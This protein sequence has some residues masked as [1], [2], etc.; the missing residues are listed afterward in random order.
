MKICE[1]YT[2]IQG[3]S[4]YAG[5]PCTFIRLTG[6]NLRCTYCDTRYA[7]DEGNEL[8][9]DAI[10]KQVKDAG[11]QLVEITGGEPLLQQGVYHLITR[12]LEDGYLVMIETNGSQDIKDIH[13]KAIVILDI[14]TPGSGAHREMNFA[15]MDVLKPNDEV[16]FV[17]T[18]QE[19]YMWAKGIIGQY[20]LHEKC[21]ILLSPAYGMLEPGHLV[22]WILADRLP[23]RLNLQIHRY[24]FP[25]KTRGV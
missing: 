24:I 9:E 8:S 6:C 25:D 20:R 17:I 15:N 14:K 5:T 7:Y 4:S 11:V 10:L 13:R 19:D 1:I 12:L 2:S 23:V 21:L 22:Q 18:C 3:E 16:K